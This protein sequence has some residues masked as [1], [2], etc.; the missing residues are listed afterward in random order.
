MDEDTPD[1][2]D[3]SW[4]ATYHV[5]IMSKTFLEHLESVPT[6]IRVCVVLY[7]VA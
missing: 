4:Y 7:L 6:A 3:H 1:S 2:L 5:H